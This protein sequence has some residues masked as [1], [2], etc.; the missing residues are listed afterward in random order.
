MKSSP[1][2]GQSSWLACTIL[3]LGLAGLAQAD[4]ELKGPYTYKN[5]QLFL[6]EGEETLTESNIVTL[7]EALK[8]KYVVVHETGNVNQL[9]IENQSDFYVYIHPGDILK[10]G[11]QDRTLPN[12]FTLSPNSKPVQVASFCVE[13]GRWRQRGG[14]A[15]TMFAGSS[16]VLN[17]KNLKLAARYSKS[18]SGVWQNVGLVQQ[19]PN[20][21]TVLESTT[22]PV[23]I[24]FAFPQ[25]F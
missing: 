1:T 18:Q 19:N 5:L 11:K 9:S 13:Q 15:V 7:E 22:N 24:G 25:Q 14:E 10:G 20:P 3:F 23:M 2:L 17:A 21:D 16:K 8:N 12:G 4:Q 6:I